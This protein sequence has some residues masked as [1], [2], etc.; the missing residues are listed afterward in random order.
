MLSYFGVSKETKD[1]Q[2][3]PD[4]ELEMPPNYAQQIDEEE[5]PYESEMASTSAKDY[6]NDSL[7]GSQIS[8]Q[9]R[10]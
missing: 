1:S 8:K 2:N 3:Q 5:H 9:A 6:H 10:F 4:T 7:V